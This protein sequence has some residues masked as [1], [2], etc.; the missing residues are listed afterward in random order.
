MV[1][2]ASIYKTELCL[3]R[4]AG[5][6]TSHLFPNPQGHSHW[7]LL[8]PASVH[9]TEC[10][11]CRPAP[12]GSGRTCSERIQQRLPM[13]TL[14]SHHAHCSATHSF[15]SSSLC[16]SFHWKPQNCHRE[17]LISLFDLIFPPRSSHLALSALESHRLQSISNLPSPLTCAS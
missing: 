15:L 16:L 12:W 17:S 8:G 9:C 4:R 10:G 1:L 7:W 5:G 13:A 6:R 2:S 11:E 3:E 14:C